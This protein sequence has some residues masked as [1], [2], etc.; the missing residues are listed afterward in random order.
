MN[1]IDISTE[2]KKQEVY[3]LF[4]S[5]KKKSDIHKYFGISDNSQGC[6]HIKDVADEIGFD[7]N[8]YKKKYCLECGKEIT[9]K[10]GNKFCSCSCSVSHRNKNSKHS[11]ITKKKI[12]E[13]LKKLKI[14]KPTIKKV[15]RCCGQEV[16]E[17]NEI[18]KHSHALF[19]NLTYFG[20]NINT[21][22]TKDVY[23]EYYKTKA[24]LEEEYYNNGLNSRELKEKYDYPK[25]FENIT[26]I[27]KHLGI[28]VRNERESQINLIIR[29]KVTPQNAFNTY[30]F[31]HGWHITWD[32]NKIYYR[33]SYELE[34]AEELDKQKIHYEVE[35]L[36]ILYYDTVL[37]SE[38]VA[39]PDFYLPKSN[40]II[41][42]KSRVTFLKQN[43]VDKFK[44]YIEL[45]YTPKLLYENKLYK[46]EDIESLEE[47]K[48]V[49]NK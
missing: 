39:I 10:Y 18:C 41:E 35:S 1:R 28:K 43:V 17:H 30:P 26:H 20:F 3:N 32:N 22:G 44:K 31:K 7:L 33:S 13:S 14:N 8:S 42:V 15:C 40:E 46:L 45:G 19:E 11:E 25:T 23:N 34:Y 29:N 5:F 36:R 47:F 4:A 27:L 16:C 12:S 6:K 49:L 9:S 2:E 38:R 37:Q 21:Y 48:Y 24:L